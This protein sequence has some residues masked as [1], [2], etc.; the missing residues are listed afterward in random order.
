[1]NK[2]TMVHPD[3]CAGDLTR[4]TARV[5]HRGCEASKP[6]GQSVDVKHDHEESDVVNSFFANHQGHLL[7]E[8]WL[9]R[10]TKRFEP[11]TDVHLS[12][13][14]PAV[15]SGSGSLSSLRIPALHGELGISTSN[16]EPVDGITGHDSTDFTSELLQRRHVF[17]LPTLITARIDRAVEACRGSGVNTV[18]SP[19]CSRFTV[20]RRWAA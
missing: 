1:M 11:A 17:S 4:V 13:S 7:H 2:Q 6:L 18:N 14:L 8:T 3:F 9:R 16:H 10:C 5:A 12:V 15:M 19:T 20:P